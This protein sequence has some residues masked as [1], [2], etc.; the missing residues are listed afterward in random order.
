VLSAHRR[1]RPRG[2]PVRHARST[3][4]PAEGE[5]EAPL[6]RALIGELQCPVLLPSRFPGAS[7]SCYREEGSVQAEGAGVGCHS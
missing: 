2:V 1:G 5:Q 7:M 6:R 3:A 4:E